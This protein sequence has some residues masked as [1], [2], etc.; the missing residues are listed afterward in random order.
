MGWDPPPPHTHTHTH[1]HS[2][3]EKESF[4]QTDGGIQISAHTEGVKEREAE[5]HLR[6]MGGGGGGGEREGAEWKRDR[7]M[8]GGGSRN[9]NYRMLGTGI[10]QRAQ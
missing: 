1:T 10:R 7:A 2:V 5:R 6:E 4:G 3:R 8:R 9:I